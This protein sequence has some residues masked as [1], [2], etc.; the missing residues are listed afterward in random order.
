M[1]KEARKAEQKY[2]KTIS[3]AQEDLRN[4]FI[5]LANEIRIR[6]AR[7]LTGFQDPDQHKRNKKKENHTKKEPKRKEPGPLGQYLLDIAKLYDAMDIETDVRI[8]RDHLFQS[9]PLHS[10]R[11]LDQ[12]YYWKLAYAPERDLEELRHRTGG[13][14]GHL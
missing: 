14:G 13:T 8:L 1:S 4:E 7:A 11:T 6:H 9:P 12:S 5:K 10:R 2:Q 3:H